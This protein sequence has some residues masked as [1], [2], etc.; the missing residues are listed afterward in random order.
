MGLNPG[1]PVPK[2]LPSAPMADATSLRFGGGGPPLTVDGLHVAGGVGSSPVLGRQMWIRKERQEEVPGCQGQCSSSS[3]CMGVLG[4]GQGTEAGWHPSALLTLT[5]GP[6]L[7]RAH[8]RQCFSPP[9]S[10]FLRHSAL[11][12]GAA[13]A[14][15]EKL[16][17]VGKLQHYDSEDTQGAPSWCQGA[18]RL[19]S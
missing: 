2:Q 9:S 6:A 15:W 19:M 17:F 11:G 18:A 10:F 7:G 8:Q 12:R 4:P 5:P 1:H 16:V 14:L 13:L 3:S